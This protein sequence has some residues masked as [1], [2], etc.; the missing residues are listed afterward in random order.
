M[1]RFDYEDVMLSLKEIVNG[2][3]DYVYEQVPAF[4]EDEDTQCAYFD[5]NGQPS[6]L[7]GHFF[8]REGLLTADDPL[9]EILEGDN[10]HEAANVMHSRGI[11]TFTPR[12]ADLLWYAQMHQDEGKPWGFSLESAMS[13][14]NN[15]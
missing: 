13:A 14:S 7:V 5:Y 12:A 3:E 15:D 11:A 6:C 10:A 8:A 2:R 4:R 1:R 9:R